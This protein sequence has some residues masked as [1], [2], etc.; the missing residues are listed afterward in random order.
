M[1]FI[2][3]G[4]WKKRFALMPHKCHVSGKLVWFKF[5]YKMTTTF[6]SRL[7]RTYWRD[8]QVHIMELLK[9]NELPERI[10]RPRLPPPPPMSPTWSGNMNKIKKG[11]K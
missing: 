1:V 6:F 2:E 10:T 5:G 3:Y 11:K 4:K 9:G 8:Q 7:S